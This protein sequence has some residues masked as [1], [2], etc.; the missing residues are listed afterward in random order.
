MT[1]QRVLALHATIILRIAAAAIPIPVRA[2]Q[3]PQAAAP[4]VA[5]CDMQALERS[6]AEFKR[7]Q[8][9]RSFVDFGTAAL[10]VYANDSTWVQLHSAKPEG[11]A[12]GA[13]N[14]PD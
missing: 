7:Q 3:P 10:W 13:L 12:V 9:L 4:S 5:V 2:G 8:T 14:A 1:R 6:E 11:L